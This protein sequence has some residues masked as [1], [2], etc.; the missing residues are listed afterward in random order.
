MCRIYGTLWYSV[1]FTFYNLCLI[2]HWQ[3]ILS[4][5]IECQLP[6]LLTFCFV[7]FKYSITDNFTWNVL[8][9]FSFPSLDLSSCCFSLSY[10]WASL[11]RGWVGL[12]TAWAHGRIGLRIYKGLILAPVRLGHTFLALCRGTGRLLAPTRIPPES[13]SDVSLLALWVA[14]IKMR[15]Y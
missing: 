15:F 10:K 7:R 11:S 6:L 3:T 8:I 5:Q 9:T 4:E 2:K 1:I 13:F 12:S 14:L